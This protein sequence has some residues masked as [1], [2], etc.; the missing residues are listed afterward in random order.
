M[1]TNNATGIY[2]Y[3]DAIFKHMPKDVLKTFEKTIL[4]SKKKV[5]LSGICHRRL[6]NSDTAV[7]RTNENL[8]DRIDK[9]ANV[10]NEE[11]PY[12]IPLRFFCEMSCNH[13]IKVDSKIICT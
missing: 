10:I 7:D 4:D 8:I 9:F 1:S 6:K 11:N 12:I 5:I 3:L 2:R 13:P